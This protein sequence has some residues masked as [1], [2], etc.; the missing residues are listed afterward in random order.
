MMLYQ[1]SY[2]RGRALSLPTHSAPSE[3]PLLPLPRPDGDRHLLRELDV[4][5]SVDHLGV[6]T[7]VEHQRR[8]PLV[9]P[10]LH[11]AKLGYRNAGRVDLPRPV[12]H[13][14][15]PVLG[16]NGDTWLTAEAPLHD[17]FDQFTV[18]EQR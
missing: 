8:R 2:I 13:D 12:V 14:D 18:A 10:S 16:E 11:R 6:A 9:L 17:G 7:D 5:D 3:T 15:D 1:L 4:A